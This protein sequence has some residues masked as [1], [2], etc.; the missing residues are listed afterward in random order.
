MSQPAS[1]VTPMVEELVLACRHS[2]RE[3]KRKAFY[4]GRPDSGIGAFVKRRDGSL[5]VRWVV[6]CWWCRL[7][8]FLRRQKPLDRKLRETVWRPS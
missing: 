4:V 1:F 3:W 7:W 8:R 2:H 5:W 6:L